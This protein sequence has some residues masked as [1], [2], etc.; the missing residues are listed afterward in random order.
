[1][2]SYGEYQ[3][4]LLNYLN[5]NPNAQDNADQASLDA[6]RSSNP[7][8]ASAGGGA[9]RGYQ[10]WL[11]TLSPEQQAEYQA[12][13]QSNF[14]KGSQRSKLA[15]GASLAAI[16]GLGALYGGAGGLGAGAGT[17]LAGASAE[18]FPGLQMST[19]LSSPGAYSTVPAWAE[20]GEP[21]ALQ[22][23]SA[24]SPSSLAA[25]GA[26]GDAGGA[27]F[28]SPEQRASDYAGGYG[29]TDGVTPATP[30]GTGTNPYLDSIRQFALGGGGSIGGNVSQGIRLGSNL[31][32]MYDTYQNSRRN[33]GMANNLNS[34]YGPDSPY[35]FQLNKALTRA[36][37]ASGRRS[38]V[39]GRNVELQAKLAEMNGRLAPTL[40]QINNQQ[41]GYNNRF[42]Y[43]GLQFADQS[44]LLDKGIRGIAGM[45]GG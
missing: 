36:Y 33:R 30:T 23:S 3:G 29:S 37:A 6:Q 20:A 22:S 5:A 1:M 43:S 13:Q 14:A 8:M 17:E 45:F 42:L 18:T 38:D 24:L 21:L 34:L 40:N 10:A 11:A 26:G 9:S 39:G 31:L 7:E 44:G 41:A 25:I 32:S 2:A 15:F 12:A 28:G 19:S 16:G 4:Q 35:A 27:Q